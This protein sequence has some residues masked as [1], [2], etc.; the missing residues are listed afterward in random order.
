[1]A[2]IGGKRKALVVSILKLVSVCSLCVLNCEGVTPV[3]GD[4][5]VD[6]CHDL[7]LYFSLR[8]NEILPAS[9]I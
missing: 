9:C 2:S 3:Y 4:A 7:L 6:A 8:P 5:L 1:M